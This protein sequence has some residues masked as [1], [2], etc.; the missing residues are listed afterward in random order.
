MQHYHAEIPTWPKTEPEVN[1]HDIIS[2]T[3]GTNGCRSQRLR[4]IFELDLLHASRNRRP[5]WWNLLINLSWKSKMAA[6]AILNFEKWQY[7]RA[8]YGRRLRDGFQPICIESVSDEWRLQL[9]VCYFLL[10][11]TAKLA[12]IWHTVIQVVTVGN[13]AS[14][15]VIN[16]AGRL[17][18]CRKR[19][20]F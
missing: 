18:C 5:L 14:V 20:E 16:T 3:L 11:S 19:C 17:K 12:Q 15:R 13:L 10:S 4:E 7:L 1:M 9:L 2:R 6:A 8:D